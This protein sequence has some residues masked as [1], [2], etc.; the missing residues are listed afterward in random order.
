MANE[1]DRRRSQRISLEIAVLVSARS[2]D[3]EAMQEQGFTRTVNRHGGSLD[4]PFRMA[5]GQRF[6]LTNP[7]SKEQASCRV[8]E[9]GPSR[10]GFFPTTFEFSAP[11]PRFWPVRCD[12][13]F[14]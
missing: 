7:Q 11:D 14:P 8:A 10:E 3:G 9:V 2:P 6:T 13:G 1:A 5:P 12:W 4:V